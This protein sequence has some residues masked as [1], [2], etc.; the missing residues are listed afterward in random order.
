MQLTTPFA[1]LN[2]KF[3]EMYFI[4][5]AINSKEKFATQRL[6]DDH[7]KMFKSNPCI[8]YSGKEP[9]TISNGYV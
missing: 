9:S 2:R 7:S 4:R 1:I 8:I 5:H 3:N 6:H